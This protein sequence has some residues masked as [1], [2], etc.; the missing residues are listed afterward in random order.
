MPGTVEFKF[1]FSFKKIEFLDLEISVEDGKLK[2]DLFIKPTNQQLY[3]EFDSNHPSHCKESIPYSQALR[4]VE[5]CATTQDRDMQLNNLKEK[6]LERKYPEE[7]VD[8]KFKLAKKR[9]RRNLIFGNRSGN[10][11]DD[12]VR[13]IFTHNK[14]NPPIHAWM[15]QCKKLL[16]RNDEAKALG[17]RIQISS[18][19]PK[20][21]LRIAAGYKD[22]KG[23]RKTPPDENPGCFKCNHCKVSCPILEQTKIF[24]STNTGKIY[25]IRQ[26]IDCDSD[27]LIY[28]ST[29]KKC[30][31]Q[32]VGKSKTPFKKRHSN[33]KQEIKKNVGGLGHH[34][35]SKGKCEYKDM[36]IT[37]IERVSEKNL[38]FLADRELWWQHQLRVFVENGG[39]GHCYRKDFK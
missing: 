12:K 30:K 22:G 29:C 36:S 39:N 6:L 19:Q 18:R 5:R 10:K 35:G 32:Y 21:L 20:N 11:S 23:V 8:A 27:W 37:L 13:L 38:K 9:D 26:H 25:K 28:L 33:H 15:R 17:S 3:L 34:Y 1:E 7:V 24:K 4:V 31:G 16:A 2:T 14:V